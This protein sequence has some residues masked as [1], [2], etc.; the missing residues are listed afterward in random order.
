MDKNDA[1]LAEKAL[2]GDEVAFTELVKI[3]L[4]PVF[5][6]LNRLVKN[7]QVAEDLTQE[8]F[9]KT[10]KNLKSY[11]QKRSFKTWIFTIAKNTAY[12]YFK[13]KKTIP[14]AY[15]EDIEGN[16]FLENAEDD[17]AD[18]GENMDFEISLKQLETAMEKIPGH[19]REILFLCYKE[20]FTL[21]EIAEILSEPYNTVKSRH[22]RAISNLKKCIASK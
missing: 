4:K 20:D 17:I 21:Q 12:D 1:K 18:P 16:S 3:Y 9:I 10:W 5:N 22:S 6:F 11:D 14:F 13:N 19:Y 8:T 2:A 7:I 15:F